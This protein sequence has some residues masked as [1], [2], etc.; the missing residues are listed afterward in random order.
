MR[1]RS[2]TLTIIVVNLVSILTGQQL[3][4]GVPETVGL[5]SKRLERIG[6]VIR[7]DVDNGRMPGAVIAIARRGKLVYYEA[8]GFLDKAAGIKMRKD[9]IFWIASMTKPI[10]AVGALMLYEQNRLLIND[11]VSTYLPILRNMR[12]ATIRRDSTGADIF[13]T[14]PAIRPPTLQDLMRHTSGMVHGNAKGNELERRYNDLPDSSGTIFLQALSRLPLYSQPGTEWTYGYGFDVLGLVIEAVTKEPL[15]EYL[16]H[17]LFKPLGMTNTSF[18]IS[19]TKLARLAKPL[20]PQDSSIP[21]QRP[22]FESGGGGAFSTATD[23]LR[24]SM[25][26]LNKGRLGSTRI[27]SRKTVEYMTANQIGPEVNVDRLR[28]FPNI[29]GY[30]F[31]LGVAVRESYGIPGIMGSPGDY[32]W[33]GSGG[34]YFWVDPKEDLAVVFLA[35]T[36]GQAR[37]HYR[38]VITS[39]VLQAIDD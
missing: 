9:A 18:W 26:L 21:T 4:M 30:G 36:P 1:F 28:S 5:S 13:A 17:E 3:P 16:E 37:L 19:P 22:S 2:L 24:F 8:F 35:V 29:N 23:Y 39:L 33:A 10:V 12:V 14:E 34:T 31:G 32:H 11:S 6:Q 7:A 20:Q 27:L 25:M 15:S 38:Q